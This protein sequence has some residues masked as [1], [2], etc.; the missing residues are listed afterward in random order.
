MT[1]VAE[2][3]PP[4]PCLLTSLVLHPP[5]GI[6]LATVAFLIASS[7]GDEALLAWA[8]RGPFLVSVVLFAV[9]IFIRHKL[10]E[11]HSTWKHKQGCRARRSKDS[12]A[13][14]LRHHQRP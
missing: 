3:A 8:W 5:A 12:I 4:P 7:A 6:A 14:L 9:A 10:E 1:I 2:F 11:T 13:L